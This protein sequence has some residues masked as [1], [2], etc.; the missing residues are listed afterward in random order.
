MTG[1]G[2]RLRLVLPALVLAAGAGCIDLSHPTGQR[3]CVVTHRCDPGFFCDAV[4]E[5]CHPKAE[6]ICSAQFNFENGMLYGFTSSAM[7]KSGALTRVT[8]VQNPTS[9]GSGALAM[10]AMFAPNP[11]P[12][13]TGEVRVTLPAIVTLG[14]K[15]VFADILLQGPALPDTMVAK[16]FVGPDQGNQMPNTGQVVNANDWVHLEYDVTYG[17]SVAVI[18]V[19]LQPSTPFTWSGSVFLDEL[20]W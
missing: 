11:E 20:G 14:G 17:G 18:G 2:A 1:P 16:L 5:T 15:K 9:C 19:I 3:P 6:Q 10:T 7:S 13:R 4:D 12:V 8:N